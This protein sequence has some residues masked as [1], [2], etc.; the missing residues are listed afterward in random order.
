MQF[1]QEFNYMDTQFY[2]SNLNHWWE[3]PLIMNQSQFWQAAGQFENQP[4]QQWQQQ[5]SLSES[6]DDTFQRFM[7]VSIS[8]QKNIEASC[9]RM[10]MQIGHMIQ[11]SDDVGVNTEVNPRKEC[12]AI[13]TGSDKTLDEKK[14]ERKEKEELSEKDKDARDSRLQYPKGRR[15][16]RIN[17]I[18]A[19]S[20]AASMSNTS[21]LPKIAWQEEQAQA[22]RAGAA[23]AP[24]MEEEL[25]DAINTRAGPFLSLVL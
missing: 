9:K 22:S 8:T 21:S 14:I 7:Q 11:K 17:P 15:R 2:Q 24:T 1:G 10:E 4:Q 23:E 18:P 6:L 20:F 16:N 12:H 5:S 19:S 25:M 13:I 3:P